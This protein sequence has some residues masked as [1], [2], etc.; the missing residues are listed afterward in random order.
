MQSKGFVVA[1]VVLTL[2]AS[3][4]AHA[5]VLIGALLGDKLASKTFNMGFEIGLNF[6]DLDGFEESER[7]NRTVFGLF[8]D[9]RFSQNF[10]LGGAVLPFAGRGAMSLPPVPTGDPEFDA[11]TAGGSMERTLGYV[12][13]PVL[14][15]WAP[16]R[17]EG[18][19]VGA[20]PS[21]GIVT[22]ATDRYEAT[23]SEGIAYKLE[24]DI[25]DGLPGLDM[26]VSV[27]VEWRFKMLSI[28]ARYTHGLTDMRHSGASEAIHSRVLT[29]TGRIYLGKKPAQTQSSP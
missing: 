11:Q 23:T 28:A 24:R 10:H 27:D 7:M 18:L 8:A 26:G 4:P 19:R 20:G 15:K 29:G 22:G 16:K 6:S 5:Q 2:L 21:L 25:A 3:V 12:E 14:L 9:W 17:D 1:V 13:I